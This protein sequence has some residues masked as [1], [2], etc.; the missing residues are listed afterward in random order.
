MPNNSVFRFWAHPSYSIYSVKELNNIQGIEI[1]NGMHSGEIDK[2]KVMEIAKKYDLL[3]L[4]NS[5]AHYLNRIGEFYNE[6][7]LEELC[8]RGVPI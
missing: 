2:L 8:A 1:E 4:T 3:L 7:D 6:I 5:D